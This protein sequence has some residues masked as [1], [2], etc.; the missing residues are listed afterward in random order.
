MH[1]GEAELYSGGFIELAGRRRYTR[2]VCICVISCLTMEHALNNR[3]LGKMI[4][5]RRKSGRTTPNLN[6]DMICGGCWRDTVEF[7]GGG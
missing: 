2:L 7:V 1:P 3:L 4:S 5:P 6:P